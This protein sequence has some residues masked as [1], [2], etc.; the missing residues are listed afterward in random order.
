MTAIRPTAAGFLSAYPTGGAAGTSTLNYPTGQTVANAALVPLAADGSL[1][2][3][4]GAGSSHLVLDV[5][6]YFQR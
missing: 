2:L 6:G 4:V 3:R 5:A 1:S